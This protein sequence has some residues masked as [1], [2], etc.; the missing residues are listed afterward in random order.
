MTER[1][2]LESIHRQYPTMRLF[3]NDC[4]AG[5]TGA[6]STPLSGGRVILD[7]ARRVSY[8]LLPGSGDLIGW[9]AITITPEMVGQKI[10]RFVSI[11]AKT[12]R[13]KI[14]DDQVKWLR[15]VRAAGGD[16]RIVK[17]LPDGI[18]EIE[19]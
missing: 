17:E 14:A 10:A 13:D 2:L 15:N 19:P 16:A 5:W 7:K 1:Q 12:L 8:G 3:R 11:E 4:G 18:K 9:E 6:K